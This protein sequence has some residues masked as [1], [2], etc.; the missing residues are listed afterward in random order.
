[1]PRLVLTT[2]IFDGSRGEAARLALHVAGV[3]F[4]DR[5]IARKDW[6]SQRD[7]YPFQALPVLD[8]DRGVI[9]HSNSINRYVGKLAGLYPKRSRARPRK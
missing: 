8:V 3:A 6:A 5:R 9:A 1:M 4:E 2:S 7:R